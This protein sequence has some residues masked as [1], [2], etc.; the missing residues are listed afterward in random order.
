[1]DRQSLLI[2]ISTAKATIVAASLQQ[3][4][5]K[6]TIINPIGFDGIN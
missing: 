1:M 4:H 5:S 3:G 2:T 6:K